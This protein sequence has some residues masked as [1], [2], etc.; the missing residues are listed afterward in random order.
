[1][2]GFNFTADVIE[3]LGRDATTYQEF[4]S[5]LESGPHKSVHNG[6]GGEMPTDGSPNGYFPKST[7]NEYANNQVLDP[8][9][10]VHHGQI[11][12]LWW[13]WQNGEPETRFE[14]YFGPLEA[15]SDRDE[16]FDATLDDIV[17]MRGLDGNVTVRDVMSTNSKL[18][19]YR[20]L[21]HFGS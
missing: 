1:M 17:T 5:R 2:Y 4:R 18:L 12:R 15:N 9:F 13:Q 14:D 16:M 10:W 3:S 7:R 20:Y 21:V 8:I 6:I 11:D 19:C